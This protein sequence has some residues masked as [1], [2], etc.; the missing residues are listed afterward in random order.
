MRLILS[1]PTDFV[2][3]SRTEIRQAGLD[4]SHSEQTITPS[5]SRLHEPVRMSQSVTPSIFSSSLRDVALQHE[6]KLETEICDHL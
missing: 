4:N 3:T 5:S 6:K 1:R 2:S